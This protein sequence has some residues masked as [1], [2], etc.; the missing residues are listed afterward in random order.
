[1]LVVTTEGHKRA[2]S[3]ELVDDLKK[4]TARCQDMKDTGYCSDGT[5]MDRPARSNTVVAAQLK[6]DAEEIIGLQRPKIGQYRGKTQHSHLQ[7][8]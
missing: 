3:G 5:V 1:M 4:M 2:G 7:Q 8:D 6:S